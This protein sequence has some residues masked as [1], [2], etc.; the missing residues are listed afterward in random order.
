MKLKIKIKK[1]Y[2]ATIKF[3]KKIA[4]SFSK[5]YYYKVMAEEIKNLPHK[6]KEKKKY[7]TSRKKRVTELLEFYKEQ[8]N[9]KSN[10]IWKVLLG[11]Y[12]KNQEAAR[13]GLAF[14]KKR[15]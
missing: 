9:N 14:P 8:L 2:H 13:N 1:R 11:V 7:S 6:N 15:R 10:S 4:R 12:R 3:D 5:T